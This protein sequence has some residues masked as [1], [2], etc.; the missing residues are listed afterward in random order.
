MTRIAGNGGERRND[1]SRTEDGEEDRDFSN[2][3]RDIVEWMIYNSEY[4]SFNLGFT[5][6]EMDFDKIGFKE[7]CK[8]QNVRFFDIN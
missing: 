6:F 2:I 3:M 5:F 4:K 7:L 1:R 8:K